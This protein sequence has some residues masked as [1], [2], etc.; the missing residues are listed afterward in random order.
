VRFTLPAQAG[1]PAAKDAK[2]NLDSI[3]EVNSAQAAGEN[4]A[5]LQDT[6]RPGIYSAEFNI[7]G[8]AQRRLFAVNTPSEET[9]LARLPLEKARDYLDR[10][11]V[12][13]VPGGEAVARRAALGLSAA[14]DDR[15]GGVR[16]LRRECAAEAMKGS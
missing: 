9:V 8:T 5:A 7:A 3:R 6:G 10:G 15:S 16:K 12:V 1:A 13:L 11:N 4:R 2:E 14:G